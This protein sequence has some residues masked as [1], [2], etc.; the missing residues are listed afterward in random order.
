MLRR[1]TSKQAYTKN[2][3]RTFCLRK[4]SLL[5]HCDPHPI[6]T[7]WLWSI[8]DHSISS[9]TPRLRS[10]ECSSVKHQSVRLRP[11]TGQ[12]GDHILPLHDAVAAEIRSQSLAWSYSD[13]LYPG[14]SATLPFAFPNLASTARD[15][16]E[17]LEHE[18]IRSW[19]YQTLT[20]LALAAQARTMIG[21]KASGKWVTDFDE[22]TQSE[23]KL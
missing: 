13:I 2:R 21:V 6:P 20:Y 19:S 4:P 1:T 14:E 22:A 18:D 9:P 12:H 3:R 5:L 17:A 7:S 16:S 10:H 11:S 23:S 8:V 15:K